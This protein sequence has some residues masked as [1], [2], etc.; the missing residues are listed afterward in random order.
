MPSKRTTRNTEAQ[1]PDP[2]D[3][4]EEFERGLMHRILEITESWRNCRVSKCRRLRRCAGARFFCVKKPEPMTPEA[5]SQM[6][7]ELRRGLNH[8]LA[9]FGRKAGT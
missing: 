4:K 1:A 6:Q 3:N 5:E 9:E 2:Y 8:R 7:A